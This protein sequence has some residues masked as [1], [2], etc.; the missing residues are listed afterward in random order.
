MKD[1]RIHGPKRTEREKCVHVSALLSSV[2][3][4]G[5]YFECFCFA[6]D[7]LG[8]TVKVS[9]VQCCLD[10]TDLRCMDKNC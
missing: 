2:E 5:R 6:C 7:F 8:Q 4:K 9:W 1:S 10:P 3:H